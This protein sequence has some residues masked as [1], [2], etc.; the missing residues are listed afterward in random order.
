MKIIKN[1]T[2]F[3]VIVFIF[4]GIWLILGKSSLVFDNLF[5]DKKT[6]SFIL[7]KTLM[8]LSFVGWLIYFV[9]LR[10]W[11]RFAICQRCGKSVLIRKKR[12]YLDKKNYFCPCRGRINYFKKHFFKEAYNPWDDI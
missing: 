4:G 6:L 5:L 2:T 10:I 12:I 1:L 9:I 3:F 8:G 11:Y 7:P